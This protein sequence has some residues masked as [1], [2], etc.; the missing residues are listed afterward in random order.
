[1]KKK[2]KQNLSSITKSLKNTIHKRRQKKYKT[3]K[4]RRKKTIKRGN[5]KKKQ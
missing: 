2:S 3:I 4:N 1:M 5:K